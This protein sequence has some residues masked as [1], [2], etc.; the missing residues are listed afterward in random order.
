MNPKN[1]QCADRQPATLEGNPH[2]PRPGPNEVWWPK[3]WCAL[4]WWTMH[5][6]FT[7]CT[8]RGRPDGP[9]FCTSTSAL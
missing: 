4:N 9:N 1:A 3:R 6:H 2:P 7:H 5:K 8:P